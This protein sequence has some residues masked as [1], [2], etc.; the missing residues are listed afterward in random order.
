LPEQ[1]SNINIMKLDANPYK[2]TRDFYPRESVINWSE[3]IDDQAKQNYIFSSFKKTLD[4]NG[5]LQYSSSV[6]ETAEAFTAKSGDE[7]GSNQ[8]YSFVDKGD[9]KIALRPELTLSIA[10]MVA[11]KFDNLRLPLRWYS[12]D[13]CFRYERPQKG[14]LREFWQVEIDIIGKEAGEV[15]L[16]IMRLTVELFLGLGAKANMFKVLYNHR[17]VLEDWV[18][19]NLWEEQ[20]K[21]LFKILDDWFKVELPVKKQLL[22]DLLGPSSAQ[23]VIA[24][25]AK[26]GQEWEEYLNL[27]RKYPEMKL[28]LDII[29]NMYPG[30][31]ID[32]TPAIIRGQAY[33]TGLIFECFDINPENPRSLF[34]GGRFDDLLDLY[35]KKAPAVGLAPGDTTIHHFLEYWGL[36]PKDLGK[37]ERVGIV[38]KSIEDI[39]HVYEELIPKI[40]G[41]NK[42]FDIDYDYDRTPNKRY[43]TLKKRGCSTIIEL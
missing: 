26:E 19:L 38:P 42:T 3:N 16:E 18:K 2:G 29:P 21:E 39:K 12:I 32:F 20:K 6:I 4:S 41:E 37:I 28:I 27:A 35:G 43:E 33:Y 7:L 31:I 10:R 36:Y 24:T 14:R 15:D 11:N 25:V 34:G 23:K 9:R 1:T 8:L 17:G 30:F 13:N 22:E 5:F 40:I